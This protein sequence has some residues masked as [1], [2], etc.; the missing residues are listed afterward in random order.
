MLQGYTGDLPDS[1]QWSDTSFSVTGVQVEGRFRMNELLI[2]QEYYGDLHDSSMY[3]LYIPLKKQS[4]TN[5][6]S[7]GRW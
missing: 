1:E 2:G 5:K 6:I 3:C 7:E 4:V